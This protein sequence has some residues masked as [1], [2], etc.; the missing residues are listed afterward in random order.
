MGRGKSEA[1]KKKML[2]A[3]LEKVRFM[4]FNNQKDKSFRSFSGRI[5]NGVEE[6]EQNQTEKIEEFSQE[7]IIR[8]ILKKQDT[9]TVLP[10]GSGK[11]YCFQG[12][13][14]FF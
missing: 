9:F 8:N 10:T 12:P 13:A 1:T 5:E 3:D 4:L 14:I 6:T 11:S 7:D 2:E